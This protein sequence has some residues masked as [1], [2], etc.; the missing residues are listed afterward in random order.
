M[1]DKGLFAD[2]ALGCFF[3][4]VIDIQPIDGACIQIG[5]VKVCAYKAGTVTADESSA[6]CCSIGI[7]QQGVA[8]SILQI[9]KRTIQIG[10]GVIAQV[11]HQIL[12]AR[13]AIGLDLFV[14]H[15]HCSIGGGVF[16][17]PSTPA[18][19]IDQAIGQG[20]KV[21]VGKV[22]VAIAIG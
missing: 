18:G 17:T 16:G 10:C 2:Y 3:G 13:A 6:K 21:G 5:K 7:I 11:A 19:I 14:H 1:S 4:P 20:G 15:A 9:G 8:L 12:D 22:V